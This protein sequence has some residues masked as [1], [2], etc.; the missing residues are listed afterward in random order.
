MSVG[1]NLE[2]NDFRAKEQRQKGQKSKKNLENATKV[3]LL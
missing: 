1:I 2:N 3:N